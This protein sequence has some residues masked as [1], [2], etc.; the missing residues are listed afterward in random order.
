MQPIATFK[1][2]LPEHGYATDELRYGIRVYSV[3]HAIRKAYIQHNWSNSVG[4]IAYDLDSP[5]ARF[6]WD[7]RM[8]PP[9]NILALNRDNGH[10]HLL[11]GLEA[12]V[13]KN[14]DSREK[15][16][17]YLAAID[18][19]LTEELGADPGYS[20][21]L[22]KNPLHDRWEVQFPRIR[23]YD[24]DELAGW[25]DLEKY[26]D[27]RRRLPAI[28][29]GR[30]CTLFETLR[31]WAYR[32]R[33]RPFLSEE[34][35]REAVLHHALV[36][37]AGFTPPLP[38]NEVRSTVK[39]VSRWVWHNLSPEGFLKRQRALSARGGATMHAKAL[40]LRQS[41]IQTAYD[42]PTLT[43]ADIAAIHGV[44]RQ[45]VNTHLRG[46]KKPISDRSV[47][48]NLFHPKSEESP[49]KSGG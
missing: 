9:P 5:T 37:N 3:A 34:M 8:C 29:Y 12:P 26:K 17:R 33:R 48:S 43:Q 10:G 47:S 32:A 14:P 23:L 44:T 6:D 46:V 45:T 20:K 42:C 18:V 36:I 22:C 25:V 2:R 49:R 27:R 16:I 15:P 38:H 31:I 30:N 7:D 39:S 40:E 41:I 19:A 24:L 35:F 1:D 28:G 11:Y 13:H 4:F 21:L